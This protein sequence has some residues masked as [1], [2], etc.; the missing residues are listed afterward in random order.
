MLQ[1]IF[2][3]VDGFVIPFSF[4][5]QSLWEAKASSELAQEGVNQS[6]FFC[7]LHT[8]LETSLEHERCFI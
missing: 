1:E 5:E 7:A 3:W 4:M 6:W 2:C 8:F